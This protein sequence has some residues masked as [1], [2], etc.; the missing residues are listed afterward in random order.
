[1]T[2][3]QLH[4]LEEDYE[5]ALSALDD[6]EQEHPAINFERLRAKLDAIGTLLTAHAVELDEPDEPIM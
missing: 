4:Q 2:E 5:A 1:V 6:L 3:E